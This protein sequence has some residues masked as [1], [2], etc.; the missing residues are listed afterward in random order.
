MAR[1]GSRAGA[2]RK[3]GSTTKRTREIAEKAFSEGI[4]P[5]EVM[6]QAMRRHAEA[7]NWDDAAEIAKNAAPYMHPKLAAV[8]HSGPN[9]DAIRTHGDIEIRI[10]DP[11]RR[12]S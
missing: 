3:K 8:E 4:T 9:G 6:L 2:G 7:D 1:G 10:I 5:L 11:K 12:G